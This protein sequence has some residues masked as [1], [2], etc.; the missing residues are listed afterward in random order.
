MRGPKG[1]LEMEKQDTTGMS[2]LTPRL[3]PATLEAEPEPLEIDVRR[4]AVM[5]IDMQNCFVKKGSA[6]ESVG[7]SVSQAQQVI[8]PIKRVTETARANGVKVVYTTH[9]LSSELCISREPTSP[10]WY[11]EFPKFYREHPEKRH[12]LSIKGTWGYEVI[13]E[14]KPCEGDICVDKTRF[15]AFSGTD[16][17]ATL[18]THYIKYIAFTGVASNCCVE[19]TIR[20]AFNFDYFPI[21]I[22]DAADPMGPGFLQES[23]IFNV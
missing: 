9:A 4:T 5:V 15:S 12:T 19:A 8:E 1:G 10:Y 16:L 13:D 23:T 6:A 11:K 2:L 22:S 20:D 17:D 21:F 7:W 14:L 3:R 18:K